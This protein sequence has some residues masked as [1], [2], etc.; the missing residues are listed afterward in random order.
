MP[1]IDRPLFEEEENEI[2]AKASYNADKFADMKKTLELENENRRIELQNEKR[3]LSNRADILE[4]QKIVLGQSVE[5]FKHINKDNKIKLQNLL[6]DE[7]KVA[8]GHGMK[9]EKT[10]TDQNYVMVMASRGISQPVIARTLGMGKTNLVK[11]FREE[12]DAGYEMDA[13]QIEGVF[14][15][16]AAQAVS[17]PRYMGAMSMLTANRTDISPKGAIDHTNSDGSLQNIVFLEGN[18]RDKHLD[19]AEIVKELQRQMAEDPTIVEGEVI[20]D[21]NKPKPA[22]PS[23]NSGENS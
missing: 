11:H 10:A 5:D 7:D 2:K 19:K 8:R 21:N 20:K 9:F 14:R 22:Q 12:L 23:E 15:I 13:S 3:E 18:G 4:A 1:M 6:V 17:D 16:C